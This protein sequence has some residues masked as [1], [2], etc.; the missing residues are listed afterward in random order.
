MLG[1]VL[2]LDGVIGGVLGGLSGVLGGC[3]GVWEGPKKAVHF[4]TLNERGLGGVL[5]ESWGILG[6]GGVA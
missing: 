4:S 6:V 2:V 3:C 5:G 1:E